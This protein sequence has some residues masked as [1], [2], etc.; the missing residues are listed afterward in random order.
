M[1]KKEQIDRENI[2]P[3]SHEFWDEFYE[4]G[5]GKGDSYE[6]YVTFNQLR[7]HLVK[8]V[9]DKDKLL[10]IGCGNS[11]LAEDLIEE[12]PTL[13]LEIISMDVCENAIA[14]MNDRTAKLSNQR[15]KSSLQYIVGDATDTKYQDQEFDGIIDKGTLDAC[16]S[17]LDFE[18]GENE[19]VMKMVCEMHRVLKSKGFFIVLSRNTLLEQYFYISGDDLNWSLKTI[20]LT[21]PS[22]KGKGITQVNYIY[23][24]EKD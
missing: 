23:L 4:T 11:L 8:L 19:I 14:R 9:K 10:H 22:N 2:S 20:E 24:L 12:T 17:T 1:G 5:E 3:S 21:T 15:V 7:P 16:L 13:S 6:W 18:C